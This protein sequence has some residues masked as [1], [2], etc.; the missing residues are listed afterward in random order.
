MLYFQ[1]E[2]NCSKERE[3]ERE[4]WMY[5]ICVLSLSKIYKCKFEQ[6]VWK[7]RERQ[8]GRETERKM[9]RETD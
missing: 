4:M 7:E 8:S 2:N 3:R 6:I 1:T 9:E 5:S